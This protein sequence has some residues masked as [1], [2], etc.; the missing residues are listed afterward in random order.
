MPVF[1]RSC[2][3]LA[4]ALLAATAGIAPAAAQQITEVFSRAS[5]FGAWGANCALPASGQNPYIVY[6][7]E[8][9]KVR[10]WLDQGTRNL[11]GWVD[12]ARMVGATTL[13][14]RVRYDDQRWGEVNGHMFD[15]VVEIGPDTWRTMSSTRV[16][17][18]QQFITNGQFRDGRPTPA[19]ARC[20]R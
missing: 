19:L 6:D 14:F 9:G 3:L 1:Q 20:R 12:S 5:M 15:T 2:L 13:E 17:D 18:G 7:N 16:H 11:G 8:A 4:M 10:R